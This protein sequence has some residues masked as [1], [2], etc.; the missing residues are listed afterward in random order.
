MKRR[1]ISFITVL[2]LCL[3]LCPM[4]VMAAGWGPDALDC[5][6]TPMVIAGDI[7]SYTLS[8]DMTIKGPYDITK[9]YVF[10][11][12]GYTYTASDAA[13]LR[14]VSTGSLYLTTGTIESKKEAGIEVQAGGFLCV[15]NAGITV[16]GQTYGLDISSGAAAQLSGGTFTGGTA[17]IRVEDGDYSALLES[18]C[19]FFDDSGNPIRLTY[20]AEKKTV[21]V[22]KCTNHLY[23]YK[24]TAEAPTHDWKCL[25][26][27]TEGVE[28]CTFDFDNIGHAKCDN[29]G[30]TIEIDIA[31]DEN[32]LVYNGTPRPGSV[33]VTV[34]FDGKPLTENTDYNVELTTHI[35]A[36][37][38]AAV[39]V[40]SAAYNFTFTEFFNVV[41]D[42]PE[43]TWETTASVEV[44]YDGYPVEEAALP[45]VNITSIYDGDLEELNELLRFSY[46]KGNDTDFTEGLPTDAGTYLIKASLPETRNY[47]AAESALITLTIKRIPE[48]SMVTI[49]PTATKPVYNGAAQELVT[50][51]TLNSGAVGAVILFARSEDGPWN[52]AIPTEINAGD[53]VVW[54][55]VEGTDN[56]ESVEPKEIMDAEIQRKEITP[57][58]EL[59]YY[60]CVYDGGYHQPKVTV[61]DGA[62]VLPGTEYT[63]TY[64]NN[65]DAGTASVTVTDKDK[66]NYKIVPEEGVSV[67]FKITAADQAALTITNVPSAVIYGDVFTLGTSGGSGNG[68]VTWKIIAGDGIA[69][70]GEKSGQVTVK[71]VGTVTV[72]ATKSGTDNDG[73]HTDATAQWTFTAGKRPVTATVTAADKTYDGKV[74]TTVTAVVEQGVVFGD[75]ITITGLTGTFSD[76]NAGTGKTVTVTGTAEIKVNDVVIANDSSEPYEKYIVT[77]PAAATA[78]IAKVVSRIITPPKQEN[79]LEYDGKAQELLSKGAVPN[80]QKNIQ[81]EY[82]L[83][84]DGPWSTDFPKGTDAGGYE[85]W[86]RAQES[87]NYT[88]IPADVVIITINPKE[89]TVSGSN[90]TLTP[91]SYV[92]DGTEKRPA[93]TV[94][95]G[96]VTISP[97]EYTVAYSNN[98]NVGTATV[99]VTDKAGGNYT[100]NGTATFGIT[101]G[102]KAVLT[103]SPQANNLTYNG[104]PQ[105]LV[106]VGTA[107]G[108]TVWYSSTGEAG[109]YGPTIPQ[110]TH[111]G[112]Y[113]VYYK[114]KG[115]GNYTDSD[116][117]HVFVTI[118]PKTVSSPVI[119]L[120]LNTM[121]ADFT[122]TYSGSPQKPGVTSV[123]DGAD[124][125]PLTEYTVSYSNNVNA[126]T[127]TVHIIDNNGGDY[128]VSGSK[129]FEITK[130]TAKFTTAPEART[131]TYNAKAQ[132]LITAG[133]AEG[134]TAVYWLEDG[135]HSTAIPTG[136][137]CGAY[138]VHYQVLGD[139]NHTD[140]TAGQVSVTITQ[141]PVKNPTIELSAYSFRYNGS[142]Q[143]PTVT[144]KDDNGYV[145]PANEYT[146]TYEGV[147]GAEADTINAGSYIIRITSK[148]G[149]NYSFTE[150]T[151]TVTILAAGQTPLTITGKPGTVY[152]G[153]TIQLSATG[154]TGSGSVK[155]TISAGDE[156]ADI[157]ETTG[158]LTIKGTGSVTVK[159]VRTSDTGNYAS[160]EDTWTFYAYPKPITAVV[161][162]ANKVYDGNVNAAVS[163]TVPGTD[164]VI[165]GV[166]GTFDN[167]NVGTNKT[168]TIHSA[169]ATDGSPNY[170]ITYPNTTTASITPAPTVLTGITVEAVNDMKYTGLPQALVIAAGAPAGGSL[171]YSLNGIDYSLVIPT[172]KDAGT[173]KVWYKVRGDSNHTDSEA[174]WTEVTIG[175]E[176]P[177]I[178]SNPTASPITSGQKLKDSIL[179]GGKAV[180]GGAEVPGT[181]TWTVNVD[182]PENGIKY[183]VTFTPY[184]RVNFTTAETQVE[185]KVTA[186]GSEEPEEPE[187]PSTTP[188]TTPGGSTTTPPAANPGTQSASVQ[189]SVR[190]GTASTVINTTAGNQ[191]VNEAI[192]SQSGNVIIQP[193]IAGDV[194]KTEVLI[195]ASAVS[196]ISSE[197]DAA[198]TV[199]TPVADVSIPNGALGML[200]SA[201]GT[202]SVITER[203]ENTVVLTLTANGKEIGDVPGGLTLTVP[204]E[205]AG[206]GTVA[207]LICE[208]GTCETVRKSVTEGDVLRIPLNGSVT[209]EIVDNSKE[210]ADVPADSWAAGAV[211]FA[212]AR[213]MFNGTGE[214][215]FSPGLTMSRAMMAAVLYNLEGRPDQDLSNEFSD[216]SS[217]AWY[218]AGVSWAAANGVIGGYGNGQAGPNDNITREQLVVMLWRYAG[219]PA[220]DVQTLNFT[221]AGQA[222][223]YAVEA[224]YWATTNGI[225]NGCGNGRL[226]PR[227]PATRA[228]AAQILKN[229]I[230]NT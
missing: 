129:T 225:L 162:V 208:D 92:Y 83:S 21:T 144:V 43:I 127:A 25:A 100:V 104:K 193:E 4:R 152:Y 217:D 68:T 175:Q 48:E 54:Y 38:T 67:A 107:T 212:S 99:T 182:E 73:N 222:S 122:G 204:V 72:L 181:F 28:S 29:C 219:S 164:L 74:T 138:T 108:G 118:Q 33:T 124:I 165:I 103:K 40:S 126:G 192:A 170:K 130:A 26:C 85:V 157:D 24:A 9:P 150:Q 187:T 88:A 61:K 112:E 143:K 42:R 167:E 49:P 31:I 117:F 113:T 11:T 160:V 206:P 86:Y 53:Y 51:G 75:K 76:A 81:V 6:N 114:V 218:T 121:T 221:D 45:K 80:D 37:E 185:V 176:T 223:G 36:G 203:M 91:A 153:D 16:I 123:A 148:P 94:T 46:K 13:A 134:G 214:A 15:K 47:F 87:T 161:T 5:E 14:V 135:V 197:T 195:P 64:D 56:Y 65:K 142:E 97:D 41:R 177:V 90:V 178:E 34:T 154:G 66:G 220:A 52:E 215:T 18:G 69:E 140:S 186:P 205:G 145:I 39:T 71:G 23:D 1:A 179:D 174:K 155:W 111:A 199:S 89:V 77:I 216:V 156:S 159:A 209:V 79:I 58:V 78:D 198:L 102:G 17:A 189:T 228:Q 133:T 125:I 60:T 132:P 57:V 200:S 50:G 211:A 163:V 84:K 173:Y 32:S 109:P 149:G 166:T 110:E 194:T 210:F 82:A 98:V 141:N 30:H 55:K 95:D 169:G 62:T 44:D 3:S 171:A 10:D 35:D 119:T 131:L 8:A 2:A 147:N 101:G 172:G 188:G 202:I 190:N 201:G 27:G 116:V 7:P 70:I 184:D 191:L 19:A 151:E 146:V 115:D 105:D 137:D 168:V 207:V 12:C 96:G 63:V 227:G 128:N 213:E 20:V 158:R 139:S 229:F 120:D 224:L 183:S 59:E 106:S 22:K 230:E 196:R 180:F 226:D 93:V 136:T